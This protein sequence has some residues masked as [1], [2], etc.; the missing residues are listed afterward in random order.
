MANEESMPNPWDRS[1]T[2]P[3]RQED[4]VVYIAG[5]KIVNKGAL[6]L[7]IEAD[8]VNAPKDV[9][10]QEHDIIL[11]RTKMMMYDSEY[12]RQIQESVTFD[13]LRQLDEMEVEGIAEIAKDVK[14]VPKAK[15]DV[16]MSRFPISVVCE[17]YAKTAELHRGDERHQDFINKSK[18]VE[19]VTCILYAR[20]YSMDPDYLR[21]IGMIETAL[22]A[23]EATSQEIVGDDIMAESIQ[24][25][26]NELREA[27]K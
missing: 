8:V 14:E 2:D 16:D 1:Q 15:D 27:Y 17:N 18:L 22:N 3:W 21:D 6:F 20:M 11:E 7:D 26:V 23:A 19:A 10:A 5:H 12:C 4:Q 25:L 13:I 9:S 24:R